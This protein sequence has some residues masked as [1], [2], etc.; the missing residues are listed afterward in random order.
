[1]G[2]FSQTQEDHPESQYFIEKATE[3]FRRMRDTSIIILIISSSNVSIEDQSI[4]RPPTK[5][6]KTHCGMEKN[7]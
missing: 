3:V 4:R 7:A 2:D 1:M 5:N 6:D